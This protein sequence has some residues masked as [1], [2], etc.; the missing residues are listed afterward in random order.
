GL[1]ESADHFPH[2]A[3]PAER[4]RAQ[5]ELGDEHAGIGQQSVLHLNLRTRPR[6]RPLALSVQGGVA[7]GRSR[8]AAPGAPGARSPARTK[9][10]RSLESSSSVSVQNVDLQGRARRAMRVL[11]DESASSGARAPRE[12]EKSAEEEARR[13]GDQH[14]HARETE[15]AEQHCCEA[16]GI[17]RRLDNPDDDRGRLLNEQGQH[18]RP[19]PARLQ[20]R[21]ASVRTPT[22]VAPLGMYG[23]ASSAH[24]VPAMSR[25]AQGSPP[26][27]SLRNSAAVIAPAGRP[28][29]LVKSAISLLS[30]SR[31]SSKS[32]IGQHWSPAASAACR[33]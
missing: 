12:E 11:G 6:S 16:G 14:D 10:P 19:P 22:P 20:A 30:C 2:L 8:D 9:E 32:G 26:A 21:P 1:V 29:V 28:P 23:L 5:T 4:H 24:A 3:P 7:P 33:T 13:E 25:W 15:R 17:L 31:Y 18:G 27:N